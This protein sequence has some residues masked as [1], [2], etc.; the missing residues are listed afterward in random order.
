MRKKKEED[1]EIGILQQLVSR[2][3]RTLR[4]V[5]ECFCELLGSVILSACLVWAF[6]ASLAVFLLVYQYGKFEISLAI[7]K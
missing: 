5:S 2:L 4:Y 7:P 3:P 1:D 6:V